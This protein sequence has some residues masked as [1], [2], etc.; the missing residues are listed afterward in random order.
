MVVLF[1]Y[2]FKK[3]AFSKAVWISVFVCMIYGACVEILQPI[4]SDKRAFDY[5]D[6]LANGI[7][8]LVG[9]LILIVIKMKLKSNKPLLF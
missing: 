7:G 8:T 3:T 1:F 6:I 9:V 4:I 2:T 5:Y